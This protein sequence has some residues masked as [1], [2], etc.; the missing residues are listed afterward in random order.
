MANGALTGGK[1]KVLGSLTLGGYDASKFTANNISFTF[2]PDN[3]RD[4][5]VGIQG[6]NAVDGDG[7]KHNLLGSTGITAY[8][9]STVPYI[10]LP[11][12]ACK[13][14]EQAFGLTFDT[15][16]ELYLLT[17]KQHTALL[18][19]NPTIT[20]TLGNTVSGGPT[21]TIALPYAAFDLQVTYP[22][23]SNT[24]SYFPLKRGANETQF[25]LGR[26]FLQEAYLTVDWERQ[27]FTVSQAVFDSTLQNLIPINPVGLLPN[28]TSTPITPT[29]KSSNTKTIGIAVGIAILII[30][31][32][33][34]TGL[35]FCLRRRR[36]R[37]HAEAVAAAESRAAEAEKAD[38]IR[39]GFGKVELDTDGDHSRYELDENGQLKPIFT[40][41]GRSLSSR[42]SKDPNIPELRGENHRP[43][44]ELNGAA[45]QF[46]LYD[47]SATP[48]ELPAWNFGELHGSQPSSTASTPTLRAQ[49]RSPVPRSQ[50]TSPLQRSIISSERG[51]ERDVRQQRSGRSDWAGSTADGSESG[52]SRATSGM[53]SPELRPLDRLQDRRERER[54]ARSR[55]AAASVVSPVSPDSRRGTM[56]LD[57]STVGSG[58]G[59]EEMEMSLLGNREGNGGG[60]ALGRRRGRYEGVSQR[61]SS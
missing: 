59:R 28:S 2:A 31:I 5:V 13:L 36:A 58:R 51:S 55:G 44:P 25:V 30:L 3:Q 38:E 17:D 4:I 18:N 53:G 12:S 20:F 6:I 35:F 9:D 46:E 37:R 60:G 48:V 26:T 61:E 29:P 24:T 27:N 14:F 52:V 33:A 42:G 10:Y 16:S 41:D 8:I 19:Q 15:N 40:A 7:T 50:A 1:G 39:S 54:I 11:L 56:G 49:T 47:P 43:V 21:T 34:L 32:I 45:P 57:E 23:V 22:L